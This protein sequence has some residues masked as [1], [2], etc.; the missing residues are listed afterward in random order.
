ML[1]DH[2]TSHIS[3][4]RLPLYL[5]FESRVAQVYLAN[6]LVR[7]K[8]ITILILGRSSPS[9]RNGYSLLLVL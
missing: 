7:Y 1:A 9:Q 6:C 2:K 5:N 8:E 3:E 4:C